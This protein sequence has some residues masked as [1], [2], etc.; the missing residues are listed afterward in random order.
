MKIAALIACLIAAMFAVIYTRAAND[1]Q[2]LYAFAQGVVV[3]FSASI[4]A[5]ILL[6]MLI[7]EYLQRRRNERNKSLKYVQQ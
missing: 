1:A 5:A 2:N 6:G 3:A 7:Q 4:A